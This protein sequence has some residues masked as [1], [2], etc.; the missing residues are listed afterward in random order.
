MLVPVITFKTPSPCAQ[1]FENVVFPPRAIYVVN[2]IFKNNAFLVKVADSFVQSTKP[3]A[4]RVEPHPNYPRGLPEKGLLQV[5]EDHVFALSII[6]V[7]NML[8]SPS[9]FATE[10][11]D[12]LLRCGLSAIAPTADLPTDLQLVPPAA[13]F[14]LPPPQGF[15]AQPVNMFF[16]PFVNVGEPAPSISQQALQTKLLKFVP[17]YR[18]LHGNCARL[19]ELVGSSRDFT[20][21]SDFAH[22]VFQLLPRELKG[23]PAFA[24]GNFEHTMRFRFTDL[25]RE[26]GSTKNK[27]TSCFPALFRPLSKDGFV[28]IFA[29]TPE[30]FEFVTNFAGFLDLLVGEG[31]LYQSLFSPI[32]LALLDSGEISIK[33]AAPKFIV[34][35]IS[36]KLLLFGNLLRDENLKDLP[37]HEFRSLCTK[38]LSF[39]VAS[40]LTRFVIS[41][42]QIPEQFSNVPLSSPSK[43]LLKRDAPSSS[44]NSH[45]QVKTS[46]A[47]TPSVPSGVTTSTPI[48]SNSGKKNTY[49]LAFLA[50]EFGIGDGCKPPSGQ[51]TCFRQ[52]LAKP[53]PGTPFDPTIKAELLRV[54]NSYRPSPFK[55]SI[56]AEFMKL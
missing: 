29:N 26:D 3:G 45:R 20:F 21:D 37:I 49:C 46:R 41:R 44:N 2:H 14:P 53:Q 15:A 23:V 39:D 6:A 51:S 28:Q 30:I 7:D 4:A 52:H 43:K 33:S 54:A 34:H 42:D 16:N 56:L 47:S 18:L 17:L 24:S 40:E 22:V 8:S 35:L 50:K 25:P 9:P 10:L 55:N 12:N 31:N 36:G 38:V 11:R 32:A 1:N 5:S 27:F 48:A 19:Q 13:L